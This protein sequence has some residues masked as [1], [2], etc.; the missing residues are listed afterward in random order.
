[1]PRQ[2]G[3]EFAERPLMSTLSDLLGIPHFTTSRGSTVRRDFLLAM[4]YAM[5]IVVPSG[6]QKDELIRL[7][8]ERANQYRMPDDRLSVGGTVTNAVL[9]EIV[10]GVTRNGIVGDVPIDSPHGDDPLS[11]QDER[12][13]SVREAAVREGQNRFRIDVLTAYRSRCAVTAADVP[14]VLEAAHI[15]PYRGPRS[16]LVSNG[17]CLRRDIHALFDRGLLAIHE[18]HYE[19]LLNPVLVAS[20]VY[21]QLEGVR[22]DVP[23]LVSHAPNRAA[24]RAHRLWAAL[25]DED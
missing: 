22:I 25:G 2:Y 15:E 19:V 16:N 9:Q 24:L 6:T 13:R 17:L 3:V 1:M 23:T 20:N 18:R 7:V 14:A 12:R 10:D 5:G 8:W 11:L 21:S 4:A